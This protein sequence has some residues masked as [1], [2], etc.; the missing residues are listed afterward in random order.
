M[1]EFLHARNVYR[2]EILVYRRIRLAQLRLL[3]LVNLVDVVYNEI[4]DSE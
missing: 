4:A 3:S 1:H 2:I